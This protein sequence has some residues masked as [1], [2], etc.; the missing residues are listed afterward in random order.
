MR[1]EREGAFGWLPAGHLHLGEQATP[2]AG[3]HGVE[4]IDL[5]V[6]FP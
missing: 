1:R 6:P 5:R 2:V 4:V 3:D